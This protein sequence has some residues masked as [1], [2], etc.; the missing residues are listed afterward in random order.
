L[1]RFI[2]IVVL[3]AVAISLAAAGVA[4]LV[5]TYHSMMWKPEILR[6]LEVDLYYNTTDSSWWLRVEA[7]NEGEA[8]AEVYKV[9]VHG[10]EILPLNPPKV[11]KAGSRGGIYV[12]L[13]REYAPETTY[14]IRLYLRSG[15]VYP[16]LE[17]VVRASA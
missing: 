6:I 16:I 1:D 5:T 2:A 14:T 13:S 4:W 17:T 3:L 15:T 7:V 9:E 12:K 8:D 10:V 11:V